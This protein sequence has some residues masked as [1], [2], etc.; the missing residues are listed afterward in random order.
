MQN[1]LRI[2]VLLVLIIFVKFSFSQQRI[3]KRIT[4]E[5]VEENQEEWLAGVSENVEFSSNYFLSQLAAFQFYPELSQVNISFVEKKIS[6]SMAARPKILSLLRAREHR[7]YVIYFNNNENKMTDILPENLPFDARVGVLGHEMAHVTDYEK[8]ST[9]EIIFYGIRYFN[10]SQRRIIEYR[11]DSIAVAH[12][13]GYQLQHFA[14]YVQSSSISDDYKSYKRD[15]YMTSE[16][17][18]VLMK[19]LNYPEKK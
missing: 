7:K 3:F 1:Y 18:E 10:R 9:I 5:F 11:T 14:E 17:I 2:S 12:G 16:E 8:L 19:E 4:P 15:I 13:L 6:T